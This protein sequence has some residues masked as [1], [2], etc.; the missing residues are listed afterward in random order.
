MKTV[1]GQ[2]IEEK[3]ITNVTQKNP[4]QPKKECKTCKQSGLTN[5]QK[6]SVI[7]G[8]YILISAIYGTVEFIKDIIS[9]FKHVY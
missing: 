8:L 3:D 9:Y 4:E 5:F 7:L 2:I 6:G 1:E